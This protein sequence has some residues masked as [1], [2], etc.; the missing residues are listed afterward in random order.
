[1]PFRLD[2]VGDGNHRDELEAL[3]TALGIVNL[4]RFHGYIAEPV[5]LA[6]FYADNDIFL[7]AS[8]VEG[9]PR[10]VWE[11]IHFGLYVVCVRVGGIESI[12]SEEDMTILPQADPELIAQSVMIIARDPA[13]ASRAAAFARNKMAQL[14]TQNPAEQ[15]KSCLANAM[16]KR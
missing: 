12:F 2:I 4:V 11:A 8:T 7:F 16:K 6:R 5:R 9:F 13:A 14:F 1:V 15:F 10:A 3:A